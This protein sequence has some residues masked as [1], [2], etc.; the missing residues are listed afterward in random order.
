MIYCYDKAIVN[1]LKRTL[2]PD[3][4]A[5]PN[6][7]CTTIDAYQATIAQLQE[8]KITYPLLLLIRDD[9]MP[10]KTDGINFTRLKKGVAV[11]IETKTNNV[12]YER[13][14]PVDLR[15][16]LQILS[17][18]VADRDEIAR[19]LFFKYE[20]QY[21]L[22]IE[23]PYEIK[24][25]INFGIRV[26]KGFGIQNSSGPSKYLEE[27]TIY[28]STIEL[29]TDGCV[30]IHNT[31]RHLKLERMSKNIKIENPKGSDSK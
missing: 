16:T 25:K 20:S 5:N 7:I 24:R 14:V 28:Q 3:G 4:G 22:H 26:D 10:I 15:Y 23:L 29:L 27:G 21:F 13:A 11:G 30:W 17:T 31:P 2:D 9:D 8:D 12:Y 1:D 18:S 6:V 19:E